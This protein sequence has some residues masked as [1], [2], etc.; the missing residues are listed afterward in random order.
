MLA[1]SLI[2]LA[3]ISTVLVSECVCQQQFQQ[4]AMKG[5]EAAQSWQNPQEAMKKGQEAGMQMAMAGAS[6]SGGG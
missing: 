3:I 4:A 1:K 2:L 6:M 5:M